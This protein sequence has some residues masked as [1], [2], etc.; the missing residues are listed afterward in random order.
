MTLGLLRQQNHLSEYSG[1]CLLERIHMLIGHDHHVPAGVGKAVQHDKIVAAA[2]H[3]QVLF[4]L[5]RSGDL[6]E[7]ARCPAALRG[8]VPV[9]PG[10]P[11]MFHNSE[12]TG[13]VR[14]PRA[15]HRRVPAENRARPW[16]PTPRWSCSPGLSVPCWA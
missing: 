7:D 11:E 3:H 14:T 13:Y 9:T 16:K 5:P 12:W 10:T 2:M 1:G 6:T 15:F 8:D 4:V